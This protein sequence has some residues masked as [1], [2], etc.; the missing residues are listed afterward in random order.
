MEPTPSFVFVQG[1]CLIPQEAFLLRQLVYDCGVRSRRGG[2]INRLVALLE[3]IAIPILA[4]L[5]G[6]G[7]LVKIPI[8]L[9][10]NTPYAFG[11]VSGRNGNVT[12]Q[13]WTFIL[14]SLVRSLC[15]ELIS[16]ALYVA[17]VVVGT[18]MALGGL[19]PFAWTLRFYVQSETSLAPSPAPLAPPLFSF[20]PAPS[21]SA[22]PPLQLAPPLEL[23]LGLPFEIIRRIAN[24]LIENRDSSLILTQENAK[25]SPLRNLLRL[26]AVCKAFYLATRDMLLF[27]CLEHDHETLH[28]EMARSYLRAEVSPTIHVFFDLSL[29]RKVI[30]GNIAVHLSLLGGREFPKDERGIRL[31]PYL[32]ATLTRLT[33]V[34]KGLRNAGARALAAGLPSALTTL[35]LS[36]NG[37]GAE[38]AKA[39]A[40]NLPPSLTELNLS[41]N[42]IGAKG[43][44]ALAEK[45]SSSPL[46]V[47]HLTSNGIGTAGAEAL[48]EKLSSSSLTLLYLGWNRIGADGA[49]ALAAKL[50]PSLRNLCLSTNQIGDEGAKA[51]AAKLSPSVTELD[52]RD[53]EI[54]AAVLTEM[55]LA[56]PRILFKVDP[57][58]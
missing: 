54:G 37:I 44:A 24:N 21:V 2:Y 16:T 42:Q 41:F 38:G 45:L 50:P 17:C 47:L 53:N 14:R 30:E 35:D 7:F 43:A 46:T 57:F 9:I 51:L 32:P 22:A 15:Q 31:L 55:R 33:L 23:A 29:Y 58:V 11:E 26:R 6:L 34:E 19:I 39:L 18:L 48:A 5:N 12:L 13:D 8:H 36:W 4:G 52:L 3:S 56:N 40:D 49:S 25:T 1:S 10:W 20:E 27:H 28:Q